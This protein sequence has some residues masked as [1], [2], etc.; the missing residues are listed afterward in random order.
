MSAIAKS[1]AMAAIAVAVIR[2][3]RPELVENGRAAL[4]LH[5]GQS[6]HRG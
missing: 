3:E 5:C 1:E 4:G 6:G 2:V